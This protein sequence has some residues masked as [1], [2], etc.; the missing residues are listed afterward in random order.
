VTTM[1][2]AGSLTRLANY[3]V[4][5]LQKRLAEVV[6]RRLDAELRLNLLEAEAEA[7][8]EN[9]RHDPEAALF[10]PTFMKG[11]RERR[12]RM[13]EQIQALVHEEEGA[14]DALARAFEELKKYEQ[15]MEMAKVAEAKEAS[16][17][18]TAALDELGLRAAAGR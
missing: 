1:K 12:A 16:R 8:A 4:E 6:E 3:E 9:A 15:V 18:E 14:R 5:T 2:W 7:E 13:D 17:R 10:H 11:W